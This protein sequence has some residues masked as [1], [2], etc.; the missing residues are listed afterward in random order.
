M[1]L[2]LLPGTARA[3]EDDTTPIYPLVAGP[4]QYV[5][6]EREISSV[7]PVPLQ[8]DFSNYQKT[9]R[10]EQQYAEEFVYLLYTL[11]LTSKPAGPASIIVTSSHPLQ[12]FDIFPTLGWHKEDNWQKGQLNL[13]ALKAPANGG[14]ITYTIHHEVQVKQPGSDSYVSVGTGTF[15]ITVKG[16][17]FA[18]AAPDATETYTIDVADHTLIHRFALPRVLSGTGSAIGYSLAGALPAGFT[19]DPA[20]VTITGAPAKFFG[21][22]S[23][24]PLTLIAE[25][26]NG[27]KAS[28]AIEFVAL[29]PA[30]PWRFDGKDA[31]V[32][33]E[34]LRHPGTS[35]FYMTAG[36]YGEIHL[37]S[38]HNL[39]RANQEG[40]ASP[41]NHDLYQDFGATGRAKVYGDRSA[42]KLTIDGT[43]QTGLWIEIAEGQRSLVIK[44]TPTV[45]GS[46]SLVLVYAADG[47]EAAYPFTLCIG[48]LC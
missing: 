17:E 23:R 43:K 27:N 13:L 42:W 24:F 12:A 8:F 9:A 47:K 34:V 15:A 38:A 26:A 32:S 2:S 18:F 1:T 4:L 19:F 25:D 29:L 35:T 28:K 11:S 33:G 31:A 14:E 48:E 3:N 16:L 10:V 41:R 20:T 5:T 45:E 36:K 46:A 6:P 40:Y 37:P 22:T 39:L 30:N 44:G 21:S 7:D